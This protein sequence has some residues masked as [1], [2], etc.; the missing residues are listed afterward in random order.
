MVWSA[1]WVRA[2][3]K[4]ITPLLLVV[5]VLSLT[6]NAMAEEHSYVPDAGFVPN[7]ETAIRIAEAVLTPIYGADV[8]SHERPFTAT[9][10]DGLWTVVGSS[11]PGTVGGVALVQ[12]SRKDGHI[13]RVTHSR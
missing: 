12:I 7:E 2:L 4:T 6:G 1:R 8:I 10:R 11:H 3:A 9:L 5:L 13:Q